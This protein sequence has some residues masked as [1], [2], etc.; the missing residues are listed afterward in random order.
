MK[1]FFTIVFLF[2]LIFPTRSSFGD[3][4]GA[5]E[6]AQVELFSES[7]SIKPGEPFWVGVRM[8]MQ[9]EWHTYWQNP[10]DAGLETQIEWKLPEGF[11][12]G[13]IRWPFPMRIE[14]PPL[15]DFGYEN[16]IIFLSE[17]TSPASLVSGAPITIA[18]KIDWLEC[19]DI[20]IPG[21]AEVD[22]SLPVANEA[23]VLNPA[24]I[25]DFERARAQIPRKLGSP[26]D[27]NFRAIRA[28]KKVSIFFAVPGNP[29]IGD[30]AFFPIDRNIY[31]YAAKQEFR[32]RPDGYELE[33]TLSELSEGEI[34]K[35]SGVLVSSNGWSG[36]GTEKAIEVE[37]PVESLG[38]AIKRTPEI[39]SPLP[40][41]T[42]RNDAADVIARSAKGAAKQSQSTSFSLW[43]AIAFA[44]TGGLFLNLMPCVLP[45]LSLKILGFIKQG[46][47]D[48]KAVRIHGFL[49][50]FGVLVSFWALSLALLALRAGGRQIGWGFQL[51]SSA[52]VAA[53]SALF[54]LLA[55][56]LFGMFEWG[57]FFARAGEVTSQT[58]GYLNSFLSGFLATIIATPCTA[59]FMGAALGFGLT[60]PPWVSFLIFTSL[61]LGM[62][63]P[64]LLLS[65]NPALLKF[66]PKPGAWMITFKKIMALPLL[67]TTIWLAWV[68]HVQIGNWIFLVLPASL[69]FLFVAARNL[70]QNIALETTQEK[71]TRLIAFA[72]IALGF[73]WATV[74]AA[75]SEAIFAETPMLSTNQAVAS[76]GISWEHFSGERLAELR[77]EGKPVFVDFT[78]AWCLTCQ[79]NERLVLNSKN[80]Q[81][82]FRELGVTMLKADWTRR[83]ENI[84][85]A[86]QGYGRSGVPLYVLYYPKDEKPVV[87]PEVLT[88]KIVLDAL[89]KI[90]S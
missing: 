55:L 33:S 74:S 70:G 23:P 62:A 63:L 73:I 2:T 12:A 83:D 50:G 82:R 71:I 78:A 20:C 21:G 67:A 16:E 4:V 48:P 56:N 8:T 13:P 54:F 9:P 39:A 45:V 69:L 11:S 28:G 47:E 6:H 79:V 49:F 44:F 34:V 42:A 7:D 59:P 75:W 15:V 10:G 81:N 46:G 61:A 52:F 38:P 57:S 1:N 77:A 58:K 25:Q 86:I 24:R 84:T 64:Y 41:A 37:V 26:N 51:Q 66:V 22:L 19:K 3:P 30:V 17:I 14:I 31:D 29:S 89:E 35:T 87:L 65:L 43:L 88:S 27:W 60:Q 36:Q 72:L 18:A 90:G 53:L 32:K 68:L 40:G 76:A 85:R 5:S 80:V